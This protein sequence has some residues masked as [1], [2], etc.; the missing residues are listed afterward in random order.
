M[1]DRI[2][3]DPQL[4]VLS[5]HAGPHY[6]NI[7]QLL[8]NMGLTLKQAVQTLNHSWT[9]SQAEQIH[10]WNQQVINNNNVAEE[11]QHVFQE[12]EQLHLQQEQQNQR[13]NG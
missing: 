10:A 1:A 2:P 9:Q 8:L 13:M 11:A 12:E 6:D 7:C 4:K 3:Q 5:N